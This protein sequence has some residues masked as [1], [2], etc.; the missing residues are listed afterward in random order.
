MT[1]K[2][3]NTDA[4]T[5]DVSGLKNKNRELHGIIKDLEKK[6]AKLTDDVEDAAENARAETGTELDKALRKITK[7][8][9]ERD[10]AVSRADKSDKGLRDYKA[11]AA[12]SAAIASAN[13]DADDVAMLTKALRADI[14]FDES[15]EPVIEGKAIDAYAKSFF[16][17]A[18]KKYVRVADH[19]GGGASGSGNSAAGSWSKAPE[20]P[21]EVNKWMRW[22]VE[23]KDEANALADSWK[24]ADLRSI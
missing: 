6:V 3:D 21:D 7:L 23:N 11:S 24:R 16:A 20:T 14:E 5:E 13:V 18:G 9:K 22:S 17:G 15:G 1:E 12:L 4:S 10:D 8:E 19:N 2:T